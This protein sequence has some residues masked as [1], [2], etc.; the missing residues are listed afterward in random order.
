VL[1]LTIP[2][3]MKIKSFKER[4]VEDERRRKEQ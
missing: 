4:K 1:E 3:I 2:K